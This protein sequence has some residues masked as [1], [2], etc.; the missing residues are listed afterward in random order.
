MGFGDV[1]DPKMTFVFKP[2]TDTAVPAEK[3]SQMMTVFDTGT[4]FSM[5]PK[6][7]WDA[8]TKQIIKAFDLKET[9]V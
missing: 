7:Y 6:T 2:S 3:K 8:Y 4:S 5:I 1:K 9:Q